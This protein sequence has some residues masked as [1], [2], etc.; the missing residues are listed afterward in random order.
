[1][2][3]G[4]T[5]REAWVKGALEETGGKVCVEATGLFVLPN[6]LEDMNLR[7]IEMRRFDERF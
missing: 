7:P 3:D 5:D 4:S 1:M 6:R 2:E